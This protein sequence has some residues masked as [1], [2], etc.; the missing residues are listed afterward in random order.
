MY[1]TWETDDSHSVEDDEVRLGVECEPLA[2]DS[3]CGS[4]DAIALRFEPSHQEVGD[5]R[6]VLND[7]DLHPGD[8]TACGDPFPQVPLKNF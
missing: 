3:V 8:A 7:Q 1:V 6:L 2:A 5:P 4:R